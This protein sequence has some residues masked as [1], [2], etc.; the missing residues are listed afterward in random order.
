MDALLGT[1]AGDALGVP[2]EFRSRRELSRDPVRDMRGYGTYNQPPGTWSDDSSL[3][4]CLAES[5]CEGYDLQDMGK[6]FVQ[7]TTHG[8]WTPH[9]RVFD[10]GNA[11]RDAI[12]RLRADPRNPVL[13]GGRG[14]NSNGNGSLMRI[15]PLVFEV[16]GKPETERREMVTHVSCLTHGHPRSIRACEIYIDMA[17]LLLDG[18]S[19]MEAYG[20]IRA[21]W[22]PRLD[23]EA[24]LSH[25]KHILKHDISELPESRISSSG[26]VVHCLE[27][28]LWCLLKHDNYADTVLAAVNLGEDTDTTAAV[29]GGLAGLV[30]GT[31]G[32]PGKWRR[33]LARYEDI[34][35][36]AKRLHAR[37]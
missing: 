30:Y 34:L 32:I 3:T 12:A 2:V 16:R 6:R 27:A 26:Y 9:G 1:A 17:L 14:E 8:Y 13:A 19:P 33:G 20:E 15:L 18:R 22:T 5:L 23:E 35:D 7:W 24:E 4:F 10:I 36:L 28:S 11:T 37:Y 29:V 25:Y 21:R 31:E